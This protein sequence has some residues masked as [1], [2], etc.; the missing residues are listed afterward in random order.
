VIKCEMCSDK[1]IHVRTFTCAW[2]PLIAGQ[3]SWHERRFI[4]ASWALCELCAS[5]QD[6]LHE[7][8]KQKAKEEEAK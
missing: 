8:M 6:T 7:W 4:A 3:K 1:A 5:A 2:S